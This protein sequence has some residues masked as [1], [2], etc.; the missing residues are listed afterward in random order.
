[1]E[2]KSMNRE[3]GTGET[4]AIGSPTREKTIRPVSPKREVGPAT[5]SPRPEK[6]QDNNKK[7]WIQRLAGSLAARIVL[8]TAIVGGGGGYAA[9]Q[10]VPAV[11]QMVDQ[12][13]LERFRLIETPPTFD[14]TKDYGT[15][16]NNNIIQIDKNMLANIATIPT[17][18]APKHD[19]NLLMPFQ[20]LPSDTSIAYDKILI[21]D[22]Q[23]F[24]VI[25]AQVKYAKE[26]NVKDQIV[27]K[28]I[29]KDTVILAPVDGLLEFYVIRPDVAPSGTIEAIN[30]FYKSPEGTI[31]QVGIFGSGTVFNPLGNFFKPLIE[32]TPDIL[33]QNPSVDESTLR[34]EVKRGQP[35]ALTLVS[36]DLNF[37]SKGWPSGKIGVGAP[38][39]YP[40]NINLITLPDSL[41]QN[42]VA[43]LE[44]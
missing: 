9:Y 13:I 14:N 7:P 11:H 18:P 19:I 20:N 16:G 10:E 28:N 37:T 4:F 15:I 22:H 17:V 24:P 31:Y 25:P 40:T 8:G 44:K 36:T 30:L 1:M 35:I 33:G 29:P 23:S 27:F 26:Q 5:R 32:A 3:R 34:V 12:Q 42:K 38:E 6:P 2:A 39:T 21:E 41:G 43:I